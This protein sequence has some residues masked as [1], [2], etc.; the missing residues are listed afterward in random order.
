MFKELKIRKCTRDDIYGDQNFYE[1][2]KMSEYDVDIYWQ[3]MYCPENRSDL[4]LW[5]NYD[6]AFARNIIIVFE[7]CNN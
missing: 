7:K 4:A 1:P 2:S 6:T 3:R 5:G